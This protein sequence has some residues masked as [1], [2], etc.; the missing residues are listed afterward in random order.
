MPDATTPHTEEHV[1]PKVELGKS[2]N[3]MRW[4][5]LPAIA[6]FWFWGCRRSLLILYS[7]ANKI[8][9]REKCSWPG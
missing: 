3:K 6:K 7:C 5:W 1:T 4:K 9:C 2:M 8:T